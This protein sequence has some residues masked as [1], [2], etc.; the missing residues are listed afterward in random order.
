MKC[1]YL[2]LINFFK[3]YESC[4]DENAK[5]ANLHQLH[6]KYEILNETDMSAIT[7]QGEGMFVFRATIVDA[8]YR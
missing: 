5:G 7:W 3:N 1:L 2:Y 8:D 6:V 4:F